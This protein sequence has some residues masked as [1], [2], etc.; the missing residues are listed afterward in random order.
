MTQILLVTPEK[1]ML[2]DLEPSLSEYKINSQWTDTAKKA[3]ALIAGQKFDTVITS[4]LLPDMTGKNLVEAVITVNAM[5]NCVVLSTLSKEDFHEAYEGLGVL[6][7]FPVKPGKD[8]IKKLLDHLVR[9]RRISTPKT[10]QTG[11]TNP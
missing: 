2:N 5:I 4:E 9:I 10:R 3:L 11:E 7:Q 6:M 8:D 1:H